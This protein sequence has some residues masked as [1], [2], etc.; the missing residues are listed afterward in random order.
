MD[1]FGEVMW[2]AENP[3]RA[4]ANRLGT[5]VLRAGEKAADRA[6]IS[7]CVADIDPD[8]LGGGDPGEEKEEG[9]EQDPKNCLRAEL[10]AWSQEGRTLARSVECGGVPWP[11][12]RMRGRTSPFHVPIAACSIPIRVRL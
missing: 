10:L 4:A 8:R 12:W 5:D 6:A 2:A 1:D 3:D 7:V 11:A 9:G